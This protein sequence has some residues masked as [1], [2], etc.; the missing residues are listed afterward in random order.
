M[1]RKVALICAQIFVAQV[2]KREG[3]SVRGQERHQPVQLGLICPNRVRTPVRLE[4]KPADVFR[5]CG[6]QVVGHIEA[7]CMLP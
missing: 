5:S 6:L 1:F 3:M 7:A 4:L 2:G